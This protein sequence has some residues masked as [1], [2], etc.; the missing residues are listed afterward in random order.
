MFFNQS[1]SKMFLLVW[2]GSLIQAFVLGAV[3]VYLLAND[4]FF[5]TSYE[6]KFEVKYGEKEKKDER[7]FKKCIFRIIL[8]LIG[9]MMLFTNNRTINK[10]GVAILILFLFHPCM[11]EVTDSLT[12]TWSN[13]SITRRSIL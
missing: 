2:I 8:S 3:G 6:R 12:A 11:E 7:P 1:D 9:F 13:E 5:T 10:I 4:P